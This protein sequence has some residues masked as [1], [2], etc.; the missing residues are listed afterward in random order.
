MAA[1]GLSGQLLAQ[2]FQLF[3]LEAGER[4]EVDIIGG[5][6]LFTD[7]LDQKLLFV[8]H[9][10]PLPNSFVLILTPGDIVA[11]IVQERI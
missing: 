2:I 4:D 7:L 5:T 1:G 10:L 6:D 11:V 3:D 9:S 8:S